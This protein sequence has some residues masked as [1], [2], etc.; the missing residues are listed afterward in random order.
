MAPKVNKYLSQKNRFLC[1]HQKQNINKLAN[2]NQI[3]FY[4]QAKEEKKQEK[5]SNYHLQMFDQTLGAMSEIVNV[6]ENSGL[7]N[8]RI[9][10]VLQNNIFVLN[11]ISQ[12]NSDF[13]KFRYA[14]A[15]L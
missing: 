12:N 13:F 8:F 9:A 14:I 5:G 1:P 4:R 3:G 11:S 15:P 7:I 2:V 10:T 6:A